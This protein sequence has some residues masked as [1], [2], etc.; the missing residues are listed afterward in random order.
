MIF[1]IGML[2]ATMHVARPG[3]AKSKSSVGFVAPKKTTATRGVAVEHAV[4]DHER[5]DEAQAVMPV[6]LTFR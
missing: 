6:I 2:V 1:G 5:L 4:L 3:E